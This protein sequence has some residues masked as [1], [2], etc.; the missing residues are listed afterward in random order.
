MLI[1][2]FNRMIRNRFLWAFIAT[3]ISVAFVLSFTSMEGCA[4]ANAGGIGTLYGKPV[5][6]AEFRNAM[7]FEL[8]LSSER[9]LPPDAYRQLER[10]TWRR[11]AILRTA[12]ELGIITPDQEVAQLIASERGFL[13]N[14]VFDPSRY[15]TFVASRGV[16][17]PTF[18]AYLRQSL[19]MQKAANMLQAAV[20]LA[21]ADVDRRLRNL[22]DERRIA[23]IH[24]SREA[25]VQPVDVS[26]NDL[27]A[28]FESN[29]DAFAEPERVSVAYVTFPYADQTGAVVTA[30]SV[31]SYYDLHAD[32]FMPDSTNL[33]AMP[34]PLD[35]VREQIEEKLGAE[36]ARYHAREVATAFVMD[37]APDRTG[38]QAP[39]ATLAEAHGLAVKTTG[40][41]T[42]DAPLA[43]LAVGPAFNRAAFGLIASDPELSFSDAISGSNAVY[44]VWAE[45]RIEARIPEFDEVRERVVPL[46][47][48]NA[49]D[50]AFLDWAG[51]QRERLVAALADGEDL[52]TAAAELGLS[53][54]TTGVFTVFDDGGDTNMLAEAAAIMPAIVDLHEGEISKAIPVPGGAV[55]ACQL[56]RTPGATS[57]VYALRPQLMATLRQMDAGLLMETWG[58]SLLKQ[59]DFH[60][61]RPQAATDEAG[62]DLD[63]PLS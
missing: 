55:L 58:E 9:G 13:V 61:L 38:H 18:E 32:E 24:I 46:A 56:E 23:T 31:Q 20:W 41:F 52:T 22:T 10:Q 33:Y 30:E 37:L 17:V 16:D 21:P 59:A 44:V 5:S 63:E 42:I 40:L 25:F 50:R 49:R 57:A 28:Y 39:F 43:E 26:T 15:R 35:E 48:S 34:L 11:L 53:V 29:R 45:Q 14:G 4:D 27:I 54:A 12:A 6:A 62:E 51:E 19:T 7:F 36:A 60:D 8:G 3:V 2:K 47:V 1:T